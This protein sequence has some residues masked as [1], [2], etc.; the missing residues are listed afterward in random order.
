V[1]HTEAVILC[2][3]VKALCPQQKFDEYTPD[4]WY[5]LLGDY[6]LNDCKDAAR[7]VG[8]RQPFIAPSEIITEVRRIRDQRIDTATLVY[9]GN[10]DETG[11]ES[12]RSLRELIRAAG[13]GAIGPRTALQA[14]PDRRPRELES[15]QRT[16]RLQDAI[17][18]IG[19]LPPRVVPG[20]TNPL[21]V[22]CP[23]CAAPAGRSC[24]TS[25]GKR[26]MAD[27][28]PARAERAQRAAAGLDDE[29]AAS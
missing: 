11:L 5:E 22:G 20:V 15:G 9:D 29:D 10:P 16:S 7:T 4:A 2:R 14:I 8:Q 28:H 19:I 1:N 17:A 3:Y 6:L 21:A 23:H 18:A 12:A 26:A 13:D 24:Q 25:H 27:P